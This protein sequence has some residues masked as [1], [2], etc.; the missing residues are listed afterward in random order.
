MSA[1]VRVSQ[2]V[3]LLEQ[4][5]TMQRRNGRDWR[6]NL[7]Q[8]VSQHPPAGIVTLRAGDHLTGM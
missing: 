3:D 6:N 1:D 4:V 2:Y 8:E 7:T 5:A